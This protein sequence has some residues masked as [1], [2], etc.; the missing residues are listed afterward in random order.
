M[1]SNMQI[2]NQF[3]PFGAY[4][5]TKRS[6]RIKSSS[7]ST[8]QGCCL[9]IYGFIHLTPLYAFAYSNT[10]EYLISMW[11]RT[12]VQLTVV[13]RLVKSRTEPAPLSISLRSKTKANSSHV[14]VSLDPN[15]GLP[16][17]A[18]V[19]THFCALKPLSQKCHICPL[20]NVRLPNS[21]SMFF[22]VYLILIL[23]IYFVIRS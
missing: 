15:T 21:I 19:H 10:R 23:L 11:W 13:Y 7:T 6:S 22:V 20:K 8:C 18:I 2:Q 12:K 9:Y 17:N 3:S 1:G 16:S 5:P 14:S 4:G